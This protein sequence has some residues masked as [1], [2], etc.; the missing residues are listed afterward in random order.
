VIDRGHRVGNHTHNH[1]NGWKTKNIDY[2]NNVRLCSE[3]VDSDLFRPPF[4]HIKKGQAR[5]LI[6]DYKIVMWN[7]ITGDFSDKLN[8]V[9]A[10]KKLKNITQAGDIVVFHDS[11]KAWNNLKQILPSYLE[12]LC[13]YE[14]KGKCL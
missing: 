7:I 4:G 8:P 2:L 3:Y 5:S 12:Y 1:L 13:Q 14:F 6:V 9:Q 11:Q 10:L